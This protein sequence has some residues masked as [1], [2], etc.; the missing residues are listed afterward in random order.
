M[1]DAQ[2]FLFG[3]DTGAPLAVQDHGRGRLSYASAAATRV[4]ARLVLGEHN[5]AAILIQ[6]GGGETKDDP[7][8]SLLLRRW[9]A[10]GFTCLAIDAPGH[11]ERAD[12]EAVTSRGFF[13]Y[14]RARVQNAI[15]LRRAIDVLVGHYGIDPARIGYW[16]VSMGGSVG[17]MLMAADQRVRAACL[18]LTGARARRTWPAVD[19]GVASFVASNL[20]VTAL[21]GLVGERPVLMLNGSHDETIAVEDSKRLYEALSG[22]KQQRWFKTGHKVTPEMLRASKD[23]LERELASR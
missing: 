17:L 5:G 19:P 9:S 13:A 6:H 16:G 22:P 11:G 3:Y 1:N 4:P 8:V 15:D 21:A 23:F 12:T 18:C 7:L 2:R 14:L 10:A 20:D